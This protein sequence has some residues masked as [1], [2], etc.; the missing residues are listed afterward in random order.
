MHSQ[1]VFLT[2]WFK[3][4]RNLKACNKFATANAV[5]LGYCWLNVTAS[6]CNPCFEHTSGSH[7]LEESAKDITGFHPEIVRVGQTNSPE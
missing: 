6:L 7:E 2:S 1:I 4:P 3:W 5:T